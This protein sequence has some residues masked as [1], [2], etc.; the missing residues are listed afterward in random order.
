MT[1]KRAPGNEFSIGYKAMKGEKSTGEV[2][3]EVAG[4]RS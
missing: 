1:P 4:D 3:G 2:A